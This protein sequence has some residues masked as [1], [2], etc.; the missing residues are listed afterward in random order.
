LETKNDYGSKQTVGVI[1]E[2]VFRLA[3]CLL[4]G[5]IVGYL[6]MD[7][8]RS[9]AGR[10]FT[11]W[12]I[13]IFLV[14]VPIIFFCELFAVGGKWLKNGK[15]PSLKMTDF[16][17]LVFTAVLIW[18]LTIVFVCLVV[19]W[20]YVKLK[21]DKLTLKDI[22]SFQFRETWVVYGAAFVF[23][24]AYAICAGYPR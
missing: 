16:W 9:F 7:T 13:A 8:M 1:I 5:V 18:P 17:S 22:F 12:S 10:S 3:A 11:G 6:G 4:L 19:W 21:K 23:G 20:L 24:I 14:L 2:V 15:R